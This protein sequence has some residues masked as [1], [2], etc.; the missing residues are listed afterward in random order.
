MNE[1][2]IKI[3]YLAFY[4]VYFTPSELFESLVFPRHFPLK[5]GLFCGGRLQRT[6]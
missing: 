3:T 1:Y 4:L 2:P 5:I 6:S